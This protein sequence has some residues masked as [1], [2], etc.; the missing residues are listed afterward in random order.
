MFILRKKSVRGKANANHR[1]NLGAATLRVTT[2]LKEEAVRT[3][4]LVP[5]FFESLEVF[6]R[7]EA[8]RLGKGDDRFFKAAVGDADIG[9]GRDED[10]VGG[11]QLQVD[12]GDVW[13]EDTK[14]PRRCAE[15]P[16]GGDRA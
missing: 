16:E 9:W 15:Q 4:A 14:R 11:R 3:I 8:G 7:E 6:E 2:H 13:E 12:L 1:L 5:V 10:R